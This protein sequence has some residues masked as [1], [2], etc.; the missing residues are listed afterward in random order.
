MN[1]NYVPI[2]TFQSNF[3]KFIYFNW[4]L[5][6]ILQRFLPYTD[7]NQSWVYLCSH[8][9]SPIKI[10]FVSLEAH[11]CFFIVFVFVCI[12]MILVNWSQQNIEQK[13]GSTQNYVFYCHVVMQCT[14]H[15][16]QLETSYNKYSCYMITGL[17]YILCS[18]LVSLMP[19][20]RRR[21]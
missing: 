3:L 8:P 4:R 14:G 16:T 17:L 1:R 9:E 7:M 21:L 18:F 2:I 10:I 20:K 6:T 13:L 19:S 11:K 15:I 12:Y 5:I